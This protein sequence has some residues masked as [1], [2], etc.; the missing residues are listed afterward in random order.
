MSQPLK[1]VTIRFA[2]DSGDG[3][4]VAGARFTDSTA[5]AGNDLATL[6]DFPAEIRAPA[7]S[8]N[9]VSA[10]Q[11]QFSARDIRT[12]GD[13]PDVLVAMNPAALAANLRDLRP[14]GML[15]VNEDAFT[16]RNLEKAG[17][18]ESPLDDLGERYHVVK[19]PVTTLNREAIAGL[20]LSTR[21]GDRCRNFFALGMLCWVYQRPLEP[22]NHW[23]ESRFAGNPPVLEANRR[24]LHAGHAFA[25]TTDLFPTSY[26]VAAAALEEGEYRNVTGNQALAWGLVAAGQLAG[27]SLFL[28][29]YPITPASDVLHELSR[30][31]EFGVRT[32]QAED[33]I[34]AASAAI[35]AS[36]AGQIGVTTTSGPGFVLK[37]EA[38]GLATMVELPLVVVD[39]QRGGPS[40]GLPTKPEQADLLLAMHGRNSESPLPVIAPSGPGDCFYAAIEAVR[41]AVESMTPV[42]LLSDATLAN[43]AEPWRIPEDA[44]LEPIE[45]TFA[46]DPQSFAPYQ[47]DPET[48]A[49]PWAVPGTPGLEHRVGGLE[50]QDVTGNI[51]YDPANHERMSQL[52]AEKVER[53]ARRIPP[54]EPVGPARGDLLLVTWGSPSGAVISAAE[55]LRAGGHSV[56]SLVLRWLNPL[57]ANLG[58]VLHRYRRILVAE[59]NHGQLVDV[60]RARYLVDAHPLN[61]MQG[62]PFTVAEVREAGER[63]AVG[64]AVA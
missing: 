23:L 7:G 1:E 22:I 62:R 52:R 28:G 15:I 37:Q 27:R 21:D 39:I 3:M 45:V 64:R 11:I 12:P 17:Y 59:L 57:P 51:S 19:V 35:G 6:P 14:N 34:A 20:G 8:L 24:V 36:Y 41:T 4:Q 58:D 13:A 10:F 43:G 16:A 31:R 49:R 32:F 26:E 55:E 25:E 33:E 61:K 60:L 46:S 2:G 48:L 50:K 38:I 18:D 29:A 53:I 42:V 5:L 63:M 30:H 40:T 47:R 56:A 9:G 44:D 54:A